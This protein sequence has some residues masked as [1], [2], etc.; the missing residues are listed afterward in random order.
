MSRY[1]ST[2]DLAAFRRSIAPNDGPSPFVGPSIGGAFPDERRDGIGLHD[3]SWHPALPFSA[4]TIVRRE[5]S[6]MRSRAFDRIFGDDVTWPEVTTFAPEPYGEDTLSCD[7]C[8][9]FEC[10]ADL[11]PD[12]NGETGAH[13]SCETR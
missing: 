7:V 9:H 5:A 4:S 8:G 10:A 3:D 2:A 11:T 12:W 6:A 13:R 1:P